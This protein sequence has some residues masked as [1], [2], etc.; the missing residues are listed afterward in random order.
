MP[1]LYTQGPTAQ[2]IYEE[3]QEVNAE[4]ELRGV[5]AG[6]LRGV[7]GDD[8]GMIFVADQENTTPKATRQPGRRLS[9]EAPIFVFEDSIADYGPSNDLRGIARLRAIAPPAIVTD[10]LDAE[11]FVALAD[12]SL[13]CD[14]E[15]SART[16]PLAT[17]RAIAP[18]GKVNAPE[19]PVTAGITSVDTA[20]VGAIF[21]PRSKGPPPDLTEDH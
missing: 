9:N 20:V 11:S 4:L 5:V 17:V 7:F 16:G 8:E 13:E 18:D 12:V 21:E 1:V 10:V 6:V 14:Q 2:Q 19:A 15:N 3:T